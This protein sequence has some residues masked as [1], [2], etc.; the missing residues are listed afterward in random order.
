[1]TEPGDL[2]IYKDSLIILAVA[3]LAVPFMHRFR[4]NT[5]LAFL[6]AGAI[7]GPHGLG[8]LKESW[9]FLEFVT[10]SKNDGISLLGDLGI[11]FLLFLIGME[12]S[13][14]RLI[15]M[16]RLVFGL[17]GAQV[18]ICTLAL[19]GIVE[20]FDGTRAEAIL[21][22]AALALSSTAIVIQILSREKRLNTSTGRASF[23]IL[24]FQ[25]LAIIPILFLVTVFTDREEPAILL[26]L[27]AALVQATLAI[28][29]IVLAGRFV[30][31][32]LLRMV[33]ATD[34]S[35]LFTATT[36]LTVMG[37]SVLAASA[38]ASMALGAF[39]AGLLIAETEYRRAIVAIIEPFK[40]LLLGVF[41]FSVGL[42]IHI[43]EA[44]LD[45]FP[46]LAA[47]ICLLLLKTLIILPLIRL[48]GFSW[49]T[50]I[51][52]GLMLAPAGEFVFVV[53]GLA[54]SGNIIAPETGT[55]VLTVSSLSMAMIP[56]MAQLGDKIIALFPGPAEPPQAL[57]PFAL[58][59]SAEA[60]IVGMG[61]VGHLTSQMLE[62]HGISYIALDRDPYVV[63]T[64]RKT[65][66]NAF[67]GN[68]TDIVFLHQCGLESMK[69]VIITGRTG[70]ETD[71]IVRV[72]RELN[73]D[74]AII[75]RAH[76]A[77]HARRLYTL[78]A[79]DAVPETIEAS[80]Q[81]SE[82]ALV[83]LG[84]SELSV[85][86]SIQGKRDSF[87]KELRTDQEGPSDPGFPPPSKDSL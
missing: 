86:A 11:V 55:F 45:P 5:V 51:K 85:L 14:Q 64:Q 74:I 62:Q 63:N 26:S 20:F 78:G 81:L 24:L 37:A 67:Y 21:I 30:M 57:P 1:M 66:E 9:H 16:R 44:L 18:L 49:A 2:M 70:S 27:G 25:D 54:A 42:K 59:Q 15:T 28:G 60:M 84:V 3:G 7:L 46:I 13:L 56:L 79:T 43:G 39:V 8:Q 53:I 80:L 19:M 77:D 6:M 17:G 10:V 22:G 83:R 82:V 48:F 73:S 61:R 69:T 76:D 40:G 12:L 34:S 75:S 35:E 65:N 32:P 52:S 68:A 58:T 23:S 29:V 87:R 71:E 31:R 4:I 72:V 50:A 38:G 33:A 47:L 36:L 41:F